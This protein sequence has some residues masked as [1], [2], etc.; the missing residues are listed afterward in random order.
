MGATVFLAINLLRTLHELHFG[1]LA[2]SDFLDTCDIL[3][4][5]KTA[6]DIAVLFV[7]DE[8]TNYLLRLR[9][10]WQ[11][12]VPTNVVDALHTSAGVD[13]FFGSQPNQSQATQSHRHSTNVQRLW[14][15]IVLQATAV[16]VII[17]P[18]APLY[19]LHFG[20][21]TEGEVR[22]FCGISLLV[23]TVSNVFNVWEDYL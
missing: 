15:G 10:L 11:R 16:V 12:F 5:M 4:F 18:L 22:A 2:E 21:H 23:V 8:W 9:A 1:Q 3:L 7:G 6:S 14:S 20:Q 17:L 13:D 19:W